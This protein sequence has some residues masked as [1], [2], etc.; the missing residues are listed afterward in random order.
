M[1]L[2]QQ[3]AAQQESD[4]PQAHILAISKQPGTGTMQKVCIGA[5]GGMRFRALERGME[6][7]GKFRGGGSV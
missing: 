4:R 6:G 7:P 1:E 2:N 3:D 5:T